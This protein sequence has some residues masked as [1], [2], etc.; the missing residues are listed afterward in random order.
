MNFV[1]FFYIFGSVFCSNIKTPESEDSVGTP[2]FWVLTLIRV[3]AFSLKVGVDAVFHCFLDVWIVLACHFFHLT[4][5]VP[6]M[7]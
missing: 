4:I 7:L 1:G 2:K 3:F 5:P 6:I